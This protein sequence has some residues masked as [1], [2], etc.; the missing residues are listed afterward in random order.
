MEITIVYVLK[1][2]VLPPGSNL[3]LMLAGAGVHRRRRRMG[4]TL[5]TIGF[6][7]LWLCTLPVVAALLART[8]E[9]DSP[10]D[11]QRLQDIDA[12]AIV[13][14][15]GGR[16]SKAPEYGDDTVSR[17]TLERLRYA[18]RLQHVTQLPLATVG[19]SAMRNGVSEG[20]LMKR[21]LEDEFQV[22]VTWTEKES[23]N[24]AEN[25]LNARRI[26]AVDHI[27]LVTHAMHMRRARSAFLHAGFGVIPAP[28][29]FASYENA[30]WS[31]FDWLPSVLAL[32]TVRHA[33]HEWLG[34]L[35]YRLRYGFD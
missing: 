17:L 30:D 21:V 10:L 16:Y 22:P 32:V 9:L 33:L 26:L 15:G 8:L 27:L 7:S 13:V 20:L 14:I 19:G 24:T 25:A 12:Q 23:R 29:G 3:L 5:V 1:A 2:L 18:A 6:V 11:P 35:W 31:L 4:T 34:V 28:M